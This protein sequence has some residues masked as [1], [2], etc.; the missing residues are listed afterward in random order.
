MNRHKLINVVLGFTVILGI[1]IGYWL[2]GSKTQSVF[3]NLVFLLN[4]EKNVE[5][6]QNIKALNGLR[7]NQVKETINFMQVH[8][9]ATLKSEGIDEKTLAQAR[10]YQRK[11]CENAC[12]GVQ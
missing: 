12:L 8:V 9:E 6:V 2:G 1:Y 5:A 4:T 11:Y 10:E 3:D 7:E